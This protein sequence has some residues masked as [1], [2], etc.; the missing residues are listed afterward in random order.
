MKHNIPAEYEHPS[1]PFCLTRLT[2]TVNHAYHT[3]SPRT[4]LVTHS[5]FLCA[6]IFQKNSLPGASPAASPRLAAA[7]GTRA[8]NG[9]SRAALT[10]S[11]RPGSPPESGGVVP[12]RPSRKYLRVAKL[13]LS[14]QRE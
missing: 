14:T 13:V 6:N 4:L 5:Y 12:G 9:A 10:I 8:D 11:P 1:K 7:P 2:T 3:L